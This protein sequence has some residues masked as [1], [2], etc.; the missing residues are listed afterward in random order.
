FKM[1]EWIP[2]L[3]TAS[4]FAGGSF[5]QAQDEGALT[6]DGYLIPLQHSTP[7]GMLTSNRDD[8]PASRKLTWQAQGKSRQETRLRTLPVDGKA[9]M[10]QDEQLRIGII[11]CGAGIF[12]L[13]GYENEPRAKVIA[14]AGLDTDRCEMLAK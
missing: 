10:A 6:D 14:L 7:G 8:G 9:A 1:S 2:F 12:H 4:G 3:P 13:E 11:G 5:A